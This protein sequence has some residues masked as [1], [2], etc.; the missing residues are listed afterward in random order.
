MNCDN[1]INN[2]KQP[3]YYKRSYCCCSTC[4]S[5]EIQENLYKFEK[6][7]DNTYKCKVCNE[8]IF[9]YDLLTHINSLKHL[10]LELS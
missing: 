4:K 1:K 7:S 5:L 8:E 6:V 10:V 2:H 9:E 3:S